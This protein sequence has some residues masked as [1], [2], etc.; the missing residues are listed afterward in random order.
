MSSMRRLILP[1][2]VLSLFPGRVVAQERWIHLDSANF[3][4]ISNAPE[5]KSRTLVQELEEFRHVF[6]ELFHVTNDRVPVTVF[7]FR[8]DKSFTPF[9]P[10]YDGKPTGVAGFFEGGR[11]RNVIA[12]NAGASENPLPIVFHEY[13]HLLTSDTPYPWPVW[14]NEGL[15]EFYSTFQVRG[16]DLTLGH[17]IA[18]HAETLRRQ[19]MYP[20]EHLF[21]I[22]RNSPEYNEKSKQG[23]FYAQSWALVHY[24]MLHEKARLRPQ[25]VHFVQLLW[26]GME[27]LRAFQES[28]EGSLEELERSLQKYVRQQGLLAAVY[29]LEVVQGVKEIEVVDLEESQVQA[30]LGDLLFYAGHLEPARARYKEARRLDPSGLPPREGL[31]LIAV[32]ENDREAARGL[33]EE[34]SEGGSQNYLVHCYYAEML[35][36]EVGSETELSQSEFESIDRP[37]REAI[38]L[39]PAFDR[40]YYLLGRLYHRWGRDLDEGLRFIDRALVLKPRSDY[41]RMTRADLLLASRDYDEAEKLFRDLAESDEEGIRQYAHRSLDR[42]RDL[43]EQEK[44]RVESEAERKR[45]LAELGRHNGPEPDSPTVTDPPRSRGGAAGPPALRRKD[46][47]A[48][49]E[50]G[51]E[52]TGPRQ[53]QPTFTSISGI[54]PLA[55]RL[56]RVDCS[57]T[58]IRYVV[59]INGQ[60]VHAA[61]VDPAAPVLFSCSVHVQEMRCGV[62]SYDALVYFEPGQ[63]RDPETGAL[64]VLAIE[65]Q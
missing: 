9:K 43:L 14:L 17:P 10:L 58:S 52:D 11:D 15:A 12:L 48:S 51:R 40:A 47:P 49:G 45:L 38:R 60:E 19:Q 31:A 21:A 57:G 54:V 18:G 22:G 27:P 3:E 13:L 53:C 62:F 23:V 7:I 44:T 4:T 8:N 46:P 39:A 36:D 56:R 1:I 24:L 41:Y 25:F 34:T 35:M 28:I 6:S 61:G 16:R 37:L 59:E 33:L 55:G 30:H 2:L 65:F 20:V 42:L 64:K 50:S 63:A 5:K 32:S 26:R 29:K